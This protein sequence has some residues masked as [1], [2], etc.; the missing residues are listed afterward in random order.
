MAEKQIQNQPFWQQNVPQVPILPVTGTA[1]HCC[2]K[3]PARAG[4]I[5]SEA[6]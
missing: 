3:L 1:G 5:W 6:P 4:A 2:G